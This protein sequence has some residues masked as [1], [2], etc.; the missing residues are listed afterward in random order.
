MALWR[1][2][3][4]FQGGPIMTT[5]NKTFCAPYLYLHEL[6]ERYKPCL[7]GVARIFK[8]RKATAALFNLIMAQI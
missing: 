3:N 8:G 5:Y 4:L 7:Q 2:L 1:I 6:L